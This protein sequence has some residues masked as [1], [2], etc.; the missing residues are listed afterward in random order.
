MVVVRRRGSIYLLDDENSDGA[1]TTTP[2]STPRDAAHP[3]ATPRDVHRII[4]L[5]TLFTAAAFSIA[6]L[7]RLKMAINEPVRLQELLRNTSTLKWYEESKPNLADFPPIERRLDFIDH[8]EK[9]HSFKTGVQV[10]IKGILAEKS[11]DMWKSC[12]EYVLVSGY[13]TE[14]G[15]DTK[16]VSL[17][18][19]QERMKPWIEEGIVKFFLM[20]STDAST[21]LPDNHFDYIY[22][23]PR[24]SYASVKEDVEH[25]WPKLRPGGIIG[26]H[27][28]L[29]SKDAIMEFRMQKGGLHIY[30]SDEDFPSWYMQK[31]YPDV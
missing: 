7:L 20:S 29:K 11:L 5:A 2:Q 31:P 12:T 16:D 18:Q 21:Q 22:L 26:G 6:Q 17:E 28:F 19:T 30:E 14:P 8:L 4:I 15:E 1:N 10:G 3:I 23:D 24:N 9:L 13:A 27:D 25:Y